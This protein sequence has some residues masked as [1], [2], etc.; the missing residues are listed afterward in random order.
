LFTDQFHNLENGRSEF[1]THEH[2]AEWKLQFS[3]FYIFFCGQLFKTVFKRCGIPF[4]S[5]IKAVGKGQEKISLVII[6]F[7]PYCIR[8]KFIRRFE[9]EKCLVIKIG[10]QGATFPYQGYP[11]FQ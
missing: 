6:P 4:F 3:R 1:A 11:F 7:W 8:I 10:E 5:S 2:D 9:K